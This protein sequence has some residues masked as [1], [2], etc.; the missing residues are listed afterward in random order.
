MARQSERREATRAALV[1]AAR[2]CFV[3]QGF[4][5][6]STEAVLARAGVSKGALYHHFTSKAELLAA[7]FEAVS[8]DTLAKA[9]AAAAGATSARAALGLALKGWLRAA[10]APEPRRIILEAGP[11]VLGFARARQIEEAITLEP[12]RRGID[13]L[14][15]HGEARCPDSDI[16]ARLL[17]AAVTELALAALQ[18]D[19]GDTQLYGFDAQL[20]ALLDALVPTARPVG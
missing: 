3:D 16:A 8:H 11:A 17:Y 6:T 12:M 18:R 7:V 10:L 4:E 15:A 9:Q 14:V 20:D 13:R 1:A 5:A 19:L 2:D